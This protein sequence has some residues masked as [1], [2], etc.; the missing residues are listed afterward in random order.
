[1]GNTTPLPCVYHRGN[2]KLTSSLRPITF[3]KT[4]H[5]SVFLTQC[6]V[7][8][9]AEMV[10]IS[11]CRMSWIA[12]DVNCNTQTA[13]FCPLYQL[14]RKTR[15]STSTVFNL[16]SSIHTDCLSDKRGRGCHP[17]LSLHSFSSLRRNTAMK[18]SPWTWTNT[19]W[20]V[21]KRKGNNIL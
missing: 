6:S 2:E 7:Q 11:H 3:F 17:Y 4:Q 10:S 13:P 18:S 1:M 5:C 20:I 16:A 21:N 14:S 8:F 19:F 15:E 12:L 9:C